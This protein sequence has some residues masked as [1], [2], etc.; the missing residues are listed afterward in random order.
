MVYTDFF[1]SSMRQNGS[2]IARVY[3]KISLMENRFFPSYHEGSPICLNLFM[4]GLKIEKK[5]L[6]GKKSLTQLLR[7]SSLFVE[8]IIF[9]G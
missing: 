8:N 5:S 2:L 1:Q 3:D 9:I 6:K 4:G 7:R